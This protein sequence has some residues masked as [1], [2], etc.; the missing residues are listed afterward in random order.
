MQKF[1]LTLLTICTLFL[2]GCFETTQEITLNEDGSG[3][4]SST[5]DLS[6]LISMAK[7]MG[8]GSEIDKAMEQVIDSTISMKDKAD[9][10]LSFS[11]EE[12]EMAKNGTLKIK[13][14]LKE[15]SFLTKLSF[16]FSKPSQIAIYNKLSGKILAESMK[17][18]VG[19]DQKGLSMD[20]MPEPSSFDDYYTIEFSQGE[21]TKKVNKEKYA[22]AESDEYLKGVKEM[23]SMGLIMKANYIINLP[24]PAQKAEG[25]NVKLSED[26]KKVTISAD[27][28]DFFADASSL[29]FKIKY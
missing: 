23:G 22:G 24:R 12:R 13:M 8:G 1:I 9:S 26:K 14:N 29:E 11:Q 16:Q 17:N 20:Q 6:G 10:I 4:I 27:I 18:Q 25:K 15:E 19:G 5:N 7:Q 2:T 28:D 21:L 3:T